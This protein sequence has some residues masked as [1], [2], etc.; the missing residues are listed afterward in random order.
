MWLLYINYKN[1]IKYCLKKYGALTLN[2]PNDRAYVL[3]S[4]KRRLILK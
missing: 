4:L 1:S 3:K 2:L